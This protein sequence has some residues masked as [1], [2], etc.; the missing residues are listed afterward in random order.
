MVRKIKNSNSYKSVIIDL[1]LA[2]YTDAEEYL[3]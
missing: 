1:G 3:F 2:E